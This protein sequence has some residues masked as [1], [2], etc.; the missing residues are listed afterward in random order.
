MERGQDKAANSKL[1]RILLK[2]EKEVRI[3]VSGCRYV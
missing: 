2:R 1:T 3:K